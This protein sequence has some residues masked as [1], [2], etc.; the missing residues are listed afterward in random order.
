MSTLKV[1]YPRSAPTF[2][3][4]KSDQISWESFEALLD[5]NVELITGDEIPHPADYDLLVA[6]R[7]TDEQ[8]TA[9]PNL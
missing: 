5:P 7:P 9:S 6:G 2:Y 1:Y 3:P 4:R 8:L